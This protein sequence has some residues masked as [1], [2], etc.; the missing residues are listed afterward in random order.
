MSPRSTYTAPRWWKEAVV[1]QVYPASFK[2]GKS[3]PGSDG[4]G[5][6]AGIIE[7]VPYLK[8]LGVDIVWSSPSKSHI[9]YPTILQLGH[10]CHVKPGTGL[11]ERMVVNILI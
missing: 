8:S 7:K 2:S 9:D 1:Y 4:F 5:D 11:K 6:V 3:V 10:R